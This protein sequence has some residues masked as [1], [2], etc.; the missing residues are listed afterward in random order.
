MKPNSRPTAGTAN[1]PARSV[2]LA[3]QALSYGCDANRYASASSPDSPSRQITHISP[4]VG[5]PPARFH[6][7]NATPIWARAIS[8]TIVRTVAW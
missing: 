7:A 3:H 5:A 2:R 4:H 6:H 8:P 1:W